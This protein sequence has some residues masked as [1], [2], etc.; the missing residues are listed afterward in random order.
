MKPTIVYKFFISIN[1]QKEL[2]EKKLIF[3]EANGNVLSITEEKNQFF[4]NSFTLD[5]VGILRVNGRILCVCHK[6]FKQFLKLH[7]AI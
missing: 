7:A 2:N 6:M 1:Q 3:W 5:C 4:L